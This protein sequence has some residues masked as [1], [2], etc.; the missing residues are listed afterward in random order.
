MRSAAF[1]VISLFTAVMISSCAELRRDKVG[2]ANGVV[3]EAAFTVE[4]FKTLPELSS[5]SG[6]VSDAKAL[7]VLPSV[8]KAGFIGGGEGGNGVL[9]V[10]NAAGAW[11]PP[12]FYTL[13]A[14]S[15][16]LQ[17]GIQDTEV[18]L[19]I[20]SEE[21]LQAILEHQGKL[22]ADAGITVGIIGVGMEASTTTNLGPDVLAFA[23]ATLGAYGGASFEGAVL[24]RRNDL[25][26]AFYGPGADPKTIL[27]QRT[28]ANPKADTLK[29]ALGAK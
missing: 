19:V 22:G 27:F 3:E 29:A 17:I 4:R 8:I 9:L 5:F 15:F 23:N 10:K 7:V 28:Y 26:E 25:N 16:G 18:I 12:A 2:V 13:G 6:Y 11:S 20:R 24:A 1:F 21:A 14:A